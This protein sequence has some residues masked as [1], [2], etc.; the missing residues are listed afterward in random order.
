MSRLDALLAQRGFCPRG[1]DGYLGGPDEKMSVD[2]CAEQCAE[3]AA[4]LEHEGSWTTRSPR[5]GTP[6]RMRGA[7]SLAT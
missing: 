5:C 2:E 3:L 4:R 6:A 7:T 1:P